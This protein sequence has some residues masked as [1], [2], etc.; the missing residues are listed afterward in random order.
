MGQHQGR[1]IS[2]QKRLLEAAAGNDVLSRA[3]DGS[4]SRWVFA[5][6]KKMSFTVTGVIRHKVRMTE[7]ASTLAHRHVT[8]GII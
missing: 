6:S 1:P 3:F 4:G 7:P 5:E 8:V 2:G